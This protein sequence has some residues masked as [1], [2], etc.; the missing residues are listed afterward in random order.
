MFGLTVNMWQTQGGSCCPELDSKFPGLRCDL[1]HK[2]A[3]HGICWMG[4]EYHAHQALLLGSMH[5][6][7]FLASM[8]KICW[9]MGG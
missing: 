5:W 8:K 7:H 4:P 2:Q 9:F 1:A 3:E 6:A